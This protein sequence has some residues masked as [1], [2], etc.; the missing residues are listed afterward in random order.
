VALTREQVEHV[1]VLAR[2]ALSADEL[3]LYR[4]QL[5]SILGHIEK[6][7]ELDVSGVP[8]TTHAVEVE[9]TPLREDEAWESLPPE[10][11][12]AGAPAREGTSFSVPRIIE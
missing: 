6:L 5:S 9:G 2:L 10:E 4:E 12:L 1:A 3:E 8:P 7:Q 11:A